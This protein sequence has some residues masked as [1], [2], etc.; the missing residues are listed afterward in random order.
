MTPILSRITLFI[1]LLLISLPSAHADEWKVKEISFLAIAQ[2]EKITGLFTSSRSAIFL[3][4]DDLPLSS[5][6]VQIS[7]PSLS[8]KK[9]TEKTLLLGPEF[10][11]VE[12]HKQARFVSTSISQTSNKNQFI[13]KGTLTIRGI[14]RTVS[15]PFILENNVIIGRTN[16]DRRWFGIGRGSWESPKKILHPVQIR[17]ELQPL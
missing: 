8:V 5:I 12:R 14:S 9:E 13:A 3:N 16:I 10:F 11:D 2:G 4:F 7:I 6:E 17:Y 1:T 15:L